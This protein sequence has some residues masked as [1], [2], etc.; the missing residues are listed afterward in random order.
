MATARSLVLSAS[1]VHEGLISPETA[2]TLVLADPLL[3]RRDDRPPQRVRPPAERGQHFLRQVSGYVPGLA[4]T[5]GPGQRADGR[6]G[7]HERQREPPAPRPPRVGNPDRTT[8]RPGAAPSAAGETADEDTRARETDT[9]GLL[10]R[11]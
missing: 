3:A 4:E 11:D 7:Q 1:A 9:D 2:Q 8:S 5:P 6:H 10:L